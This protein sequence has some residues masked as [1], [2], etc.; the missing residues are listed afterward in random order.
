M[1][2]LVASVA[3]AGCGDGGATSGAGRTT[4][5]GQATA[6]EV[7]PGADV[8]EIRGSAPAGD[9]T[10]ALSASV[11]VRDGVQEADVYLADLREPDPSEE[12]VSGPPGTVER[13]GSYEVTIVDI[14]GID[15]AE[16]DVEG[17]VR[18]I[19]TVAVREVTD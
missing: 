19:V 10:V 11:H 8:Y 4:D 18:E 13:I 2:A 1:A 6:V 9:A 7:P 17:A 5:D 16:D 14:T 3:L 12:R 15:G